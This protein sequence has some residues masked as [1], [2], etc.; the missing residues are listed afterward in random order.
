MCYYYCQPVISSLI[1]LKI[2]YDFE[3]KYVNIKKKLYLPKNE[4]KK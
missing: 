4:Y 1:I 2:L 3:F